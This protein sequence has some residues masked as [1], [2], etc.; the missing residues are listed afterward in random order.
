MYCLASRKS[1]FEKLLKL[2]S[3]YMRI[4]NSFVYKIVFNIK[5][6]VPKLWKDGLKNN[7][8]EFFDEIRCC[9]DIGEEKINIPL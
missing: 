6:K 7:D 1:A 2:C 9:R 3:K 8:K 5:K 4:L